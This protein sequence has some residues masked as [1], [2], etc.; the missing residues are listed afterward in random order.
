MGRTVGDRQ[1]M[2][3][4]EVWTLIEFTSGGWVSN[5]TLC[6]S[7]SIFGARDVQTG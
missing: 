1:K 2:G 3:E 6:L 4:K 7:L 5:Q